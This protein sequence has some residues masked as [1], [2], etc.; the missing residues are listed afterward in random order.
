M[1]DSKVHRLGFYEEAVGDLHNIR[2]ADGYI[3]AS[4]G[5]VIVVL[6]LELGAK[7]RPLIGSRI[8]ILRTEQDYRSRIISGSKA[9]NTT[10]STLMD[11][12]R[13]QA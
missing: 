9:S 6:P 10:K 11:V 7:L 1:I 12:I 8:G 2:E 3:L 13:C 4:I 5:P